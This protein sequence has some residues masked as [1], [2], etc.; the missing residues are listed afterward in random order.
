M[1]GANDKSFHHLELSRSPLGSPQANVPAN[2]RAAAVY[3]YIASKKKTQSGFLHLPG[4]S[5]WIILYRYMALLIIIFLIIIMPISK[6][7]RK[8]QVWTK[9]FWAPTAGASGRARGS[10][11]WRTGMAERCLP[12]QIPRQQRFMWRKLL[13]RHHLQSQLRRQRL[14]S[15]RRRWPGPPVS[16]RAKRAGMAGALQGEAR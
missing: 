5:G 15:R 2:H 8:F 1:R 10:R 11:K 14:G 13:L 9:K 3:E 6:Y 7:A 4:V 12:R 16:Q